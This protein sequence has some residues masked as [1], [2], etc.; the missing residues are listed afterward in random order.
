MPFHS[1]LV[2]VKLDLMI[3]NSLYVIVV[4]ST[5]P[6]KNYPQKKK[7]GNLSTINLCP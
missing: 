4:S 2:S 6:L 5:A 1:E 7:K 3:D